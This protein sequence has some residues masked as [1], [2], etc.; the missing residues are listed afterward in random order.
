MNHLNNLALEEWINTNSIT[1][2]TIDGFWVSFRNFINENPEEVST[3]FGDL[4]FEDVKPLMDTI[5]Y[6]TIFHPEY[7]IGDSYY[8]QDVISTLD[9]YYKNQKIGYYRMYFHTDGECYDDSLVT[10][11]TRWYITLKLEALNE[12]QNQIRDELVT[13]KCGEEEIRLIQNIIETKI[14]KT[15]EQIHK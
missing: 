5:E 11:W 4:C 3:F 8:S 1:E 14:K 2:R 10:E 9:V 12:L 13:G 7:Q 6:K 15:R